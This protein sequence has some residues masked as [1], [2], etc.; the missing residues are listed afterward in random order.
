MYIN[1]P[2]LSKNRLLLPKH[3]AI[4]RRTFPNQSTLPTILQNHIPKLLIPSL[5]V[6]LF[7]LHPWGSKPSFF[8]KHEIWATRHLRSK[9]QIPFRISVENGSAVPS[10]ST[11]PTPPHCQN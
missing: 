6:V 11:N 5:P 7:R 2:Q 1:Q 9:F 8:F 10:Q 4:H 3:I